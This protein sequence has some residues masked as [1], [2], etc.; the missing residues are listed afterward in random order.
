MP[1]FLYLLF[2]A[3]LSYLG[4]IS[5]GSHD[6]VTSTQYSLAPVAASSCVHY[7][8]PVP[9]SACS[10][11]GTCV[12]SISF[13]VFTANSSRVD[14]ST[15]INSEPFCS[16]DEGWEGKSDFIYHEG[17]DCRVN[18]AAIMALFAAAI[19]WVVIII[20]SALY[21]LIQLLTNPR[22]RFN[23]GRNLESETSKHHKKQN[24]MADKP[25]RVSASKSGEIE[26]K[27]S[28][29][30]LL[31]DYFGQ[32]LRVPLF[33]IASLVLIE[34]SLILTLCALHLSGQRIATDIAITVVAATEGLLFWCFCSLMG[35]KFLQLNINLASLQKNSLIATENAVAVLK[36]ALAAGGVIIAMMPVCFFLSLLDK[37]WREPAMRIYFAL[38]LSAVNVDAAAF[39]YSSY[40][41]AQ[42]LIEPASLTAIPPGLALSRRKASKKLMFAVKNLVGI[43]AVETIFPLFVVFWPWWRAN[44]PYQMAVMVFTSGNACLLGLIQFANMAAGKTANNKDNHRENTRETHKKGEMLSPAHKKPQILIDK[45]PNSE[46]NAGNEPNLATTHKEARSWLSSAPVAT[47][48]TVMTTTEPTAIKN[49]RSSVSPSD[50]AITA[51]HL[52]HTVSNE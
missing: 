36:K 48:L 28:L 6:P 43:V 50:E 38:H 23:P 7:S 2:L 16:C 34:R 9:T 11:H 42:I 20:L 26:V 37:T 21:R 29:L 27:T 45:C 49:F 30:Y 12:V 25:S 14:N 4:P 46:D 15:S 3:I 44:L 22:H 41:V 13:T 17:W 52:P 8:G 39:A 33:Q 32:L 40:T 1:Q 10:D 31:F 51:S 18:K 47:E 35:I 19:G 5:A 24:L